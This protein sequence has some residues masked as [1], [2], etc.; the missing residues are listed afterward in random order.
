MRAAGLRGERP[1]G[2]RHRPAGGAHRRPAAR[3]RH[4]A[5]AA[6][7]GVPGGAAAGRAGDPAAAQR[8]GAGAGGGVAAAGGA[9]SAGQAG[10]V[11]AAAR[12]MGFTF[13]FGAP[14]GYAAGAG[15]LDA[16]WA[17]LYG[18]AILWDPRLRYDLRA[19]GP[20]GRRAGRRALHGAA[21]RRAD[22]RRSWPPATPGPCCC[23]RWRAG[24][25][26]C[27][28]WFYP[29]LLL[30]AALLARQVATLD[31]DDP[32]L[33]L[34]LFKANRE[35][36]LAVGAGDP[37][38]AGCERTPAA[39]IRAHTRWPRA[40]LVPEIALHLATE[41]TPDLAGH[42]GVAAPRRT[43]SRRSGPSPGRAGRRWRGMCWTTRRRCR[44]AGAG[45][46]RRVRHRRHRLR[47]GGRG[48]G[49]G[50]GDRPAGHRRHRG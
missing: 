37:R 41:I 26:G 20:R 3:L 27:A 16:A 13:G 22:R 11:V 50:G 46:R 10:D 17:V 30:P 12:C 19:S 32:A 48:A 44:A 23:W 9:L 1:V 4:A 24:W 6:G 18:A 2:P 35:V 42:R 5:A 45:F 40:P 49:R 36:G 31:I 29:A 28:G 14:L 47:P 43:S 8:A 15:R 33:C 34:R 39:F 38:S 7:A 25:P 21:V